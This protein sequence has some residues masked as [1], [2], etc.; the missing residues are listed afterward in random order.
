MVDLVRRIIFLVQR[1]NRVRDEVHGNN[2]DAIGRAEGKRRKPGEKNKRADHIELICFRAA[3]IAKNDAGA[4]N[5]AL[6]RPAAAAEPCARRISS[7]ARRDRNRSGSNQSKC[8]PATTSFGALPGNG[9]GADVAEA[10]QA[11]IVARAHGELDHFE[12]PAKVHIQAAFLRFAIER[13]GA[14]D[15][16]IGGADERAVIVLGQA[17]AGI[18]QIAQKNADAGVEKLF[19]SR[20]N[21]CGAAASARG[22]RALP[23]DRAREPA[24]SADRND[25]RAGSTRCG[26][27]CSRWTRSGKWPQCLG[28]DVVAETASAPATLASAAPRGTLRLGRASG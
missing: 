22:G 6:A 7:C 26:H 27:R 12:R 4:K 25:P 28:Q 1:H 5:R 19:E 9:D 3:A 23:A 20:G 11:V 24:G 14:M 18:G 2:I 15:H 8:L 17:E 21:P 10:A 16:G 13:G